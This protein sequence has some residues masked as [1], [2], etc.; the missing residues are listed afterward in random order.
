[1]V[2]PRGIHLPSMPID[3][4]ALTFVKVNMNRQ[5]KYTRIKKAPVKGAFFNFLTEIS[6]G[7]QN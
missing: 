3:D 4:A 6:L 5:G 7:Q 1:M 2:T